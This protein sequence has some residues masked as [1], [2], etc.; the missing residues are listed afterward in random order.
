MAQTKQV[1]TTRLVND[2]LVVNGSSIDLLNVGL[3]VGSFTGNARWNNMNST[4]VDIPANNGAYTFEEGQNG[5]DGIIVDATGTEI[6][7]S[8]KK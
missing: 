8:I 3:A 2:I 7:I 1:F 5:Y 6:H 4:P